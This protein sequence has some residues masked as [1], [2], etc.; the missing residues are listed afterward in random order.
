M[1]NLETLSFT[2][3]KS[4]SLRHGGDE[5]VA[6]ILIAG[7]SLGLSGL[8]WLIVGESSSTA[9]VLNYICQLFNF[10]IIKILN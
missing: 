6:A 10:L 4:L 7:I 3:S 1:V 9:I 5:V 2:D 8:W